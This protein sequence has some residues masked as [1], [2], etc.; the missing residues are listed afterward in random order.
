METAVISIFLKDDAYIK[1]PLIS[2]YKSSTIVGMRLTDFQIPLHH[3]IF[4]R[5]VTPESC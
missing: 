1:A 4:N 3:W 5:K 2:N